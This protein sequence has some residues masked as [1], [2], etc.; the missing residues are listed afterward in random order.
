MNTNARTLKLLEAIANQ[1]APP[2]SRESLPR[3]AD[4]KQRILQTT[5][6]V[7]RRLGILPALTSEEEMATVTYSIGTSG[8]DYSTIAA[9]EADLDN[10]A[11]YSSGDDA[12]GELYNDSA[13]DGTITIDGG[14]TSGIASRTLRPA[15]GEGHDG[16]AGS[17][18]RIVLTSSVSSYVI[19]L[20]ENK[21]NRLDQIEIDANGQFV[22]GFVQVDTDLDQVITRLIG[23]G[24]VGDGN[25]NGL[26]AGGC[27]YA[28]CIIYDLEQTHTGGR[29]VVGISQLGN[30]GADCEVRNCTVWNMQNNNGS[31]LCS[32]FRMADG[33]ANKSAINCVGGGSTGTTAGVIQDWYNSSYVN[34]ITENN[35]SS[36]SSANGTGAVTNVVGA[37][38][39]V[40]VAGGSEDFHLKSGSALIDVGQDLGANEVYAVDIDGRNRD[41]EGDTFWDIGADEFVGGGGPA[42][43]GGFPYQ[44][45]YG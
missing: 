11:L 26:Q 30:T 21:P 16:T 9:W 36:D 31:G 20:N 4:S 13:F 18:V 35:A 22:R 6:E 7:A 37:D 8:R 45:Y 29:Y 12:V 34:A 5:E 2:L 15:T 24:I 27:I 23:H 43:S 39:F 14:A 17:G 41:T 1:L 44:I 42:P 10:L 32:A 33:N 3:S 25:I 28:N 38:A 19:D 40:S